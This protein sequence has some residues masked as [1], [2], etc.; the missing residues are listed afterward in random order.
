VEVEEGG[1]Q[2]EGT[3]GGEEGGQDGGRTGS[4]SGLDGEG[5]ELGCDK[6]QHGG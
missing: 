1:G 4:N 5:G 2:E 6:G 3:G